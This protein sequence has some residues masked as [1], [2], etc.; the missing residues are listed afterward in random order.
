[1][2]N[3]H[4]TSSSS[5]TKGDDNNKVEKKK[6]EFMQHLLHHDT[7]TSENFTTK[8]RTRERG[9]IDDQTRK[10]QHQ[11]QLSQSATSNAQRNIRSHLEHLPHFQ[12]RVIIMRLGEERRFFERRN[13]V[14]RWKVPLVL[15]ARNADENN[16]ETNRRL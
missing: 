7:E 9:W 12:N 14:E 3:H 10:D 11:Q 16:S 6:N 8:T 15:V 4:F 1:M 2:K 13:Q 5:Q